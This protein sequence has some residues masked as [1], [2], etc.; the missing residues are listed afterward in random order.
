MRQ[1]LT[2]RVIS[3]SKFKANPSESLRQSLGESFAVLTNNEPSFY[4]VSPDVYEQL[5]EAQWEI[6]NREQL[7]D[8]SARR[9]QS[10]KVA[11][12]DI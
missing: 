4:V 6:N 10:V 8:R 3:I 12:E 7:L 5:I 1:I 11:L 2:N 9:Q